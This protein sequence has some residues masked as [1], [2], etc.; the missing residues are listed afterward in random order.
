MSLKG[1]SLYRAMIKRGFS[2]LMSHE[3]W[4]EELSGP[5]QTKVLRG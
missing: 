4:K 5:T 3:L 1:R 2:M